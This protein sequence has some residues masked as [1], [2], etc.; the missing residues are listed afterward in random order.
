M[1]AEAERTPPAS[2]ASAPASDDEAHAFLQERLAY[3]GKVYATIGISF[4]LI[5]NLADLATGPDYPREAASRRLHVDCPR[6][7][8]HVSRAMGA[9]PEWPA[10]PVSTPASIDLDHGNPDGGVPLGDDVFLGSRRASWPPR[11]HVALLLFTFGLL[12]RAVVIP[13]SP[14][15]TLI[16]G[17]LAGCASVIA[18]HFWY[19]SQ[20]A[21]AVSI[22]MH[23]F[24]TAQWCLGAVVVATLASHIIFGLRKQVREAWQLGQ[25]TLLEKIGEGGMGAVYRASHAM[26]R[27]PTAVKLLEAQSRGKPSVSSGLNVRCSSPAS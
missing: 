23:A 1:T 3:L 15:R 16:L 26:L 5:G 22:G 25:Y 13:S 11:T 21:S 9:E 20:P 24:W 17:L 18:S 27:R 10:S 4:Y 6:R 8:C 19:V 2:I 12:I 7:V 14:R